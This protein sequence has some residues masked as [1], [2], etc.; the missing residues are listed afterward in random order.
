MCSGRMWMGWRR[1][2]IRSAIWRRMR[3]RS[4][5]GRVGS[6]RSGGRAARRGVRR[7]CATRTRGWGRRRRCWARRRGCGRFW[8]CIRARHAR[9]RSASRGIWM[10]WRRRMRCRP[11]G[12]CCGCWRRSGRSGRWSRWGWRRWRWRGSMCGRSI[13]CTARR[14]GRRGIRG[15]TSTT[16]ATTGWWRK[17]GW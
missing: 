6:A 14:A 16:G 13:A 12:G 8:G 15:R 3:W 9:L 2:C 5:R 7:W 4:W 1:C 10:R 11:A 17:S